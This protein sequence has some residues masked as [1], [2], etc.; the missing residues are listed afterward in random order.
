V[1]TAHIS[2]GSV[3]THLRSG[4]IYNNQYCKL[5]AE[6]VSEKILKIGR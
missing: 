3:E 5:S 4:G 2:Q 6:C 1:Q